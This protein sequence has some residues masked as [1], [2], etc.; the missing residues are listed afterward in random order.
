MS[1][2]VVELGDDGNGIVVVLA[3]TEATVGAIV[4]GA[5]VEVTVGGITTTP[6]AVVNEIE[7]GHDNA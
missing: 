7:L 3:G 5:T 2:S 4:L 1:S 6:V